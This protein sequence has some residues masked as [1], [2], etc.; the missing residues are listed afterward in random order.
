MK[1]SGNY[2]RVIKMENS[3]EPKIFTKEMTATI[4]NAVNTA[5]LH[6]QA[7]GNKIAYLKDGKI[8]VE[9]PKETQIRSVNKITSKS[10]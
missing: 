3:N 7:V 10:K 5:L 1:N 4:K 6:H 8:V 2:L 9:V